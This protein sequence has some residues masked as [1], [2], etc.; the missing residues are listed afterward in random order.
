MGDQINDL[1][2]GFSKNELIGY[3]LILWAI[4]F[5]FS[6]LSG[7][8]WLAEG[9]ASILDLIVDSLWNI[10]ELGCAVILVLLGMKILNEKQ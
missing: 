7:F 3:F 5:V 10:A 4:T 9:H 1:V 8:I 6:A 2:S